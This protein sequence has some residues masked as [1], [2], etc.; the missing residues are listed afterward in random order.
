MSIPAHL[1]PEVMELKSNLKE[2][3]GYEKDIKNLTLVNKKLKTIKAELEDNIQ[4]FMID[5][6][7][8]EIKTK[9]FTLEVK[10]VDVYK[11][12]T[13]KVIE[14]QC[15]SLFGNN[16]SKKEELMTFLYDADAREDIEVVKLKKK[17]L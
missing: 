8:G 17:D 4:M 7:Y 14:K 16:E 1:M 13:K 9:S 3:L 6:Q 5:S 15:L 2:Y 10:E 11:G 12:A